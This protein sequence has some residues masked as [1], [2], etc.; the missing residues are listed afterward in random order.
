MD[1]VVQ[2]VVEGNTLAENVVAAV[3]LVGDLNLDLTD[4]VLQGNAADT[5]RAPEGRLS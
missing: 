4:N 2:S 3:R 1:R 5:V